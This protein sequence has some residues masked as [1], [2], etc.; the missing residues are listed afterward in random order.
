M[1]LYLCTLLYPILGD[2]N[3]HMNVLRNIANCSHSRIDLRE[4]IVFRIQ[5][6]Q[7]LNL[8]C[9]KVHHLTAPRNSFEFEPLLP[10]PL[11]SATSASAFPAHVRRMTG[12]DV[13]IAF[14]TPP[15]PQLTFFPFL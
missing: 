6:R 8:L 3:N 11:I 12:H 14:T 5:A 9:G 1:I 2:S 7:R 15:S 13:S 4:K 10:T